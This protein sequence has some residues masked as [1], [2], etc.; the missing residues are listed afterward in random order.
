MI[1]IRPIDADDWRAFREL[2]LQA[3]REAPH[4]YS[5][6]LADW[7]GDRDTEQRWRGRLTGVPF[8]VIAYLDDAPAEI[9][10]GTALNSTGAV[11][12]ISLWVAAFARGRGVG[13]A[14]IDA[15]VRWA[16]EQGGG[17]VALQVVPNNEHAIA[18]YRRHGFAN[19]GIRGGELSMVLPLNN[20]I[21]SL[22]S[23]DT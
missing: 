1:R 21:G 23:A 20:G 13:D 14:L 17:S 10:S 6:T 18:L 7:Q 4:A 19:G 2:R 11:E 9:V 8:N 12:L 5:S 15:V 22:D 3:L 16:T